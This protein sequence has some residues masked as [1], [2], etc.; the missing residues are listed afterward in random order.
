MKNKPYVF[1]EHI[2]G[3]SLIDGD[4]VVASLRAGDPRVR[5]KRRRVAKQFS[6]FPE[7][8]GEL[9]HLA[10]TFEHACRNAGCDEKFIV[11]TTRRAHSLIKDIEGAR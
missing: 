2:K 3:Y 4:S 6:R 11:K 9:K 10:E 8:V 1:E 5:D 7:I